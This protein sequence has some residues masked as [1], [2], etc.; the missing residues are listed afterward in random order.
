MVQRLPAEAAGFMKGQTLPLRQSAP[1]VEVTYATPG[2]IAAGFVQV[3]RVPDGSPPDGS[4]SPVVGSEFQRA[5]E[6]A[7]R[8][9]GPNRRL[10]VVQE[11]RQPATDP[12]FRCAVLEGTYGRQPGRS[13]VCVGALSGQLL[14]LGASTLDAASA[15]SSLQAFA[16]DVAVAMRR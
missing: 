7:V 2:R 9:A 11:M 15:Q 10:T 6:E 4:E 8:D 5:V 13:I 12:L 1:G 16:R 14:R 3:V